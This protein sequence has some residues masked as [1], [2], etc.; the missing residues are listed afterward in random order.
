MSVDLLL[1]FRTGFLTKDGKP[2]NK[3]WAALETRLEELLNTWLAVWCVVAVV[4]RRRGHGRWA[5]ATVG[6]PVL[7]IH[8][9]VPLSLVGVVGAGAPS[10]PLSSVTAPG[11]ICT[12]GLSWTS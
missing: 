10:E 9:A 1:N 12:A 5:G 3:V 7:P 8:S 4:G 2:V 6:Q 11:T